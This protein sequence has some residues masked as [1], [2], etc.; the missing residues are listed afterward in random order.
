MVAVNPTVSENAAG[1]I[2]RVGLG[3]S[4]YE[5]FVPSPLPPELEMD[6]EVIAR[7]SEADR[8]IGELA[9]LGG[10]CPTRTS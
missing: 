2:V 10:R 5:A 1:K 3:E 4:A 9:G 7:L 6:I 8:A